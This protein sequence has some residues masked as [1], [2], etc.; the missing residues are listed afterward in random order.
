MMM[1]TKLRLSNR[2]LST[3]VSLRTAAL[4]MQM[5]NNQRQA[6]HL[7]YLQQIQRLSVMRL[8][9]TLRNKKNLTLAVH[10]A[11]YLT[12][13]AMTR[14]RTP[15]LKM[16]LD[17]EQLSAQSPGSSLDNIIHLVST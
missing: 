17:S 12:V 7:L 9:A 16:N 15:G 5:I 6:Y 10:P 2:R 13:S 14:M 3:G 11:S 4:I 1:G 8:S